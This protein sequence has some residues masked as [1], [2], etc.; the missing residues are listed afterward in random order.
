MRMST[1]LN[2]VKEIE[3]KLL[4]ERVTSTAFRKKTA[5]VNPMT[6]K[7]IER[8]IKD[9]KYKGNTSGLMKDVKK[10]FP[11]EY[12]SDIVQD[13]M[14]KHAETNEAVSPAQQAAIAISKKERGE[15]PKDEKDEGNTFGMALKSARDKGEK[16]F[17]V[18]GKKYNVEDLDTKD[19][20]KVKE[21]IKKLKGASQAHAGQAKDLEKAVSEMKL[22]SSQIGQL[23]KAFEPL[24]GKKISPSAGD[25][26]IKI[27]YKV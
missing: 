4:S 19:E 7:D 13:M 18:S 3:E 6:Q 17:V 24:R 27:M 25:K 8:M 12:E 14:K 5:R 9:R 16:T 26:L 23:K 2:E 11:D 21:I 10:K 1:L 15:K 22:N 20:P